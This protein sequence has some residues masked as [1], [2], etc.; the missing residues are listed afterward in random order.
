MLDDNDYKKSLN[1]LYY[2]II[3]ITILETHSASLIEPR[4]MRLDVDASPFSFYI[5]FFNLS[6]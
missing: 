3:N 5:M 1:C 6:N 4:L 2:S